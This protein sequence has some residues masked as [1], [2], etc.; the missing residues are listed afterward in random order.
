M[1]VA[2]VSEEPAV[3]TVGAPRAD[4][5]DLLVPLVSAAAR[6]DQGAFAEL[7]DEA[8]SLVYGVALSVLSDDDAAQAAAVEAWTRIWSQSPAF[9]AGTTGFADVVTWI[10]AVAHQAAIERRRAQPDAPVKRR[11]GLSMLT[12]GVP[13]QTRA[14]RRAMATL[15]SEQ[16]RGIIASYFG[17]TP[18]VPSSDA[19][20]LRDGLIRLRDTLA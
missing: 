3:P 7:Y 6:G 13:Q 11:S 18:H 17:D 15:T 5:G 12:G 19:V 9:A 2:L 4:S 16:R 10:T 14:L 1:T 8:A 20:H